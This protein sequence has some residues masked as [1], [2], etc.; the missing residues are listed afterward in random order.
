MALRI[1]LQV[2]RVAV[3]GEK[4]CARRG[5]LGDVHAERRPVKRF[6]AGEVGDAQVQVAPADVGRRGP[7]GGGAAGGADGA[8]V[9]VRKTGAPGAAARSIW[10][11]VAL[12]TPKPSGRVSHSTLRARSVTRRWPAVIG[13]E[14][15]MRVNPTGRSRCGG[16]GGAAALDVCFPGRTGRRGSRMRARVRRA[17]SASL[18]TCTRVQVPSR[19]AWILA[20]PRH[21]VWGRSARARAWGAARR[22]GRRRAEKSWPGGGRSRWWRPFARCRSGPARGPA[23]GGG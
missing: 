12:R 19:M 15:I 5:A 2:M 6:A 16:T 4:T 17:N 9:S 22:R 20:P 7:G 21:G 1:E 11:A 23:G 18:L 14:G 13:R 8:P 10:P 3:G